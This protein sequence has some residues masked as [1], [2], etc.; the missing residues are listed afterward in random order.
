[1]TTI[2]LT[3]LALVRGGASP[4]EDDSEIPPYVR[5]AEPSGD[6]YG[7]RQFERSSGPILNPN[8]FPYAPHG[9]GLFPG[10]P[11]R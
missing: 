1:M 8:G 7:N 3:D 10:D 9:P 5:M 2:D 6:M 11:S 4:F